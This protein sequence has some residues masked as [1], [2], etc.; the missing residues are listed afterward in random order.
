MKIDATAWLTFSVKVGQHFK[1]L[2]EEEGA[3]RKYNERTGAD[4]G[5]LEAGFYQNEELFITTYCEKA[6]TLE[7][8][9]IDPAEFSEE[10]TAVWH[11]QLQR[12]LREHGIPQVGPVA[13]RLIADLDD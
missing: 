3:L 9:Q 2:L 1:D 13:L 8:V 6:E 7:A 11:G 10:R 12:F 4:L 5:F